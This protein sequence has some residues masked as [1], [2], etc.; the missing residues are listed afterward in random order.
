MYYKNWE[1]MPIV[2]TTSEC[3]AVLR[4]SEDTVLRK[5]KSGELEAT[6]IMGHWRI[7]KEHLKKQFNIQKGQIL[8]HQITVNYQK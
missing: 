1:V 7:A 5:I 8:C 4:V 2:L 6:K 3:A